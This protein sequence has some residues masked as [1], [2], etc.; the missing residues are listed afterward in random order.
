M[1][2]KIQQLTEKL[3]AEGIEKAKTEAGQILE[4][5]R[6]EAANIVHDARVKAEKILHVSREESMEL[7]KNIEGEIRIAAR[8]A[9]TVVRQN[10]ADMITLQANQKWLNGAFQDV[11]F[12]KDI[13]K[14]AIQTFIE[15]DKN[16]EIKLVLPSHL[17][18]KVI[19]YLESHIHESFHNQVFID[20]SHKIETGFRIGPTSTNYLISF[21]E[22]DFDNFIK[23]FLRPKTIDLLFHENHG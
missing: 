6:A 5:A 18:Q 12:M 14:H 17:D 3:Y 19:R 8:H 1:Q 10:I 20:V 23:R 7:Q 21:T 13:M 22:Q 15:L 2:D 11:D 4:A 16:A 9:F